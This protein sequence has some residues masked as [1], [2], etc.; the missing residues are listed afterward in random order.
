MTKQDK[1]KLI[2]ILKDWAREQDENLFTNFY[3]F[4]S[5]IYQTGD[6][7]QQDS[8]DV[9]LIVVLSD[10]VNT[11]TARAKASYVLQHA[12]L[13]LEQQLLTSLERR[14][15]SKPIV[16]IVLVTND[17]L[18][19]NIHKSKSSSF[20]STN[21][22]QNLKHDNPINQIGVRFEKLS[23][24]EDCIQALELTQEYRNKY[25]SISPNGSVAVKKYDENTD[26]LPKNLAR[27]A[28]QVAFFDKRPRDSEINKFDVN[29]GN[30]YLCSLLDT[31]TEH[32]SEWYALV[33]KIKG[34]FGRGKQSLD[35]QDILVVYEVLYEKA[36]ELIK[37]QIV[38][39][40]QSNQVPPSDGRDK[41]NNQYIKKIESLEKDIESNPEASATQ[42]LQLASPS[43]TFKASNR[44]FKMQSITWLHLSD[45]HQQGEDF[46]RKVVRDALIKDIK[47]RAE[48]IST[49]LATID[50]IV[51]SG[52]VAFFGKKEE[53][54]MAI[55]ELFDPVLEATGLT[56]DKLFIIPGNHDL[57]RKEI[58][59]LPPKIHDPFSSKDEVIEWLTNDKKRNKLLEPFE[60]YKEFITQYTGQD[61]PDYASI[62]RLDV[63]GKKIALLGIN[64][65]LMCARNKIIK[66]DKEEVNDYGHLIVGKPQIYDALQQIAEADIRIAVLHH[67]FNWLN[68]FIDSQIA[69]YLGK[70]CHFILQGHQHMQEIYINN[71]TVGDCV[72][73][74]GGA[75]YDRRDSN[76]QRY[77]NSYNFVHLSW[78]TKQWRIFPRRWS[79]RKGEWIKDTELPNISP[80]EPFPLPKL[81]NAHNLIQDQDP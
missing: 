51:F 78:E 31:R 54:E 64:S 35:P 39:E 75:S 71:G 46:N 79:E 57:N 2:S 1:D 27:S 77:V 11:P 66:N 12:K 4:G 23:E 74:P 43:S 63:N 48:K 81:G 65:A 30:L 61:S 73:I 5:L 29:E 26:P 60:A 24:L 47:E 50:F 49:D 70:V 69:E 33:R 15:A 20:F 17:E 6:Q 9:D 3:L 36:C 58:E 16:S 8:S 38:R 44:G 80:D 22:F 62:K 28:A 34:R 55:Q 67:P 59:L 37:L 32:S 76:S 25:L 18:T 7:F 56:K 14:D 13:N 40:Q 10:S 52:D 53:Y 19:W 68:N 41:N 72:I 45:W 21:Q 42:D